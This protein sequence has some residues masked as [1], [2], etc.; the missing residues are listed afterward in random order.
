MVR[1]K[2]GNGAVVMFAE[3]AVY[4]KSNDLSISDLLD[5][6]Y[7]EY[8]YFQEQLHSKVM[9]GAEGAGKIQQLAQ[10]YSGKTSD[11]SR[12]VCCQRDARF[13]DSGD[14]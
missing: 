10:S 14:P 7:A 12:W 9:E 5:Q 2:D 13:C 11:R 6:I 1:D 4:A 8:G 3:L